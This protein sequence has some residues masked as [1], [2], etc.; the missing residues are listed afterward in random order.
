MFVG[1]CF[2]KTIESGFCCL[3]VNLILVNYKKVTEW[4]TLVLKLCTNALFKRLRW[5]ARKYTSS[6]RFFATSDNAINE[7]YSFTC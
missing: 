6:K 1:I 3:V 7:F 5:M 2:E 4:L